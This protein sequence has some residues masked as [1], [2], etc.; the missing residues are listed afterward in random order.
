[1]KKKKQPWQISPFSQLLRLAVHFSAAHLDSGIKAFS[2]VLQPAP[3][4][5]CAAFTVFLN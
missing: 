5:N 1:M 4:S 2:L 3:H